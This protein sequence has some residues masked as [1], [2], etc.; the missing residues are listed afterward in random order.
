[1]LDGAK[2]GN[3]SNHG[4][5]PAC[6]FVQDRSKREREKECA[7]VGDDSYLSTRTYLHSSS[8]YVLKAVVWRTEL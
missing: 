7:N 1:M 4:I 3:L 5:L 2:E 6:M 8:S